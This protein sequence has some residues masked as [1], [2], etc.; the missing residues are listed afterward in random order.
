[1][2]EAM[3][4]GKP[5]I[6]TAWSGNLDFMTSENSRLVDF[7][8][9]PVRSDHPSYRE[10]AAAGARWA[11]ASV[12]EAARHMREIAD[13]PQAAMALGRRA[14]EDMLA[15]R[16]IVGGVLVDRLREVTARDSEVWTT[17]SQ[18]R[19]QMKALARDA[20]LNAWRNRAHRAPAPVRAALGAA[21]RLGRR[22]FR[23]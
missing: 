8:F 20:E 11:D 15:R 23:L 3:T 19:R 22:M 4:L 17:H 9:V 7:A 6:A 21:Y 12:A 10:A 14:R 5:T 18:H 1:M 2:M 13:D 16:A